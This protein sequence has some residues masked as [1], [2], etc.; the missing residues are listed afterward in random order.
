MR[1]MVT[2]GLPLADGIIGA[3]GE[4]SWPRPTRPGDVMQVKMTVLEVRPSRSKPDQGLVTVEADTFN[5]D[6]DVLQHLVT[7]VL[8]FRRPTES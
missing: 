3:G 4:I 8:V 1:L 2:S 7:K 6:G 5:Q